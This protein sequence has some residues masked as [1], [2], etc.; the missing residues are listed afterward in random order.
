MHMDLRKILTEM[1]H[2]T[3]GNQ[4]ELA[5]RLGV[6]QPTI[7][8]WKA[9]GMKPDTMHHNTIIREAKALGLI[10]IPDNVELMAV[11][12]IGYVG[13]GGETHLYAEGQGPFG[14]APMPPHGVNE[15]TVAVVVRGDSMAGQADDGW[16][17]YYNDRR[18]PPTDDLIGKLCV[19]GL[20]DGRILIKRLL[21]GRGPGL[22]D[23]YS[24]IGGPI[25]DQRVEWAA[26]VSWIAPQ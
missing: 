6:T 26:R 15:Q 21:R 13:A 25:T 20:D 14:E 9:N 11:P 12:I 2:A 23:L 5:R 7:S 18:E 4:T 22:F 10:H 19:V 3:G 24:S 8:R 16:L 17:I 1:L